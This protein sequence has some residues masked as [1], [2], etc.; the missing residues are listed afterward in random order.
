MGCYYWTLPC[1][2]AV[3]MFISRDFANHASYIIVCLKTTK[4]LQSLYYIY[5]T[6][7]K[8]SNFAY[9]SCDYARRIDDWQFLVSKCTQYLYILEIFG[10]PAQFLFQDIYLMTW[11]SSRLIRGL[12]A[13]RKFCLKMLDHCWSQSN[14]NRCL[15]LKSKPKTTI[16][17]ANKQP[18]SSKEPQN[19]L[20]FR[21]KTIFRIRKRGQAAGNFQSL[22]LLQ[23]TRYLP[24]QRLLASRHRPHLASPVF[25][26]AL[27]VNQ[28][29]YPVIWKILRLFSSP[30]LVGK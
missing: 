18:P 3:F 7:S 6:W 12:K 13:S 16:L 23:H 15:K 25:L 24:L 8:Q 5:C 1:F 29:F 9:E 2:R 22:E 14:M 21:I 11:S 27:V 17:H 26:E 4:N 10:Q 30:Q 28:N 20:P 19:N